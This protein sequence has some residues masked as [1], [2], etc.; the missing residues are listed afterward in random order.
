VAGLTKDA[1]DA[2]RQRDTL[3]RRHIERLERQVRGM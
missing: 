3:L 1:V 2:L